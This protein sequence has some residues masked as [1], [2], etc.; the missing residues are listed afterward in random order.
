MNEHALLVSSA[1]GPLSVIVT[2]PASSPRAAAVL[3][4]GGG[5]G[6]SG[7]NRVFVRLARALAELG[8]VVVRADY[9]GQGDS[10]GFGDAGTRRGDAQGDY[11]AIRDLFAWFRER[12][13]DLDLILIGSC[14]GARVGSRFAAQDPRLAA[15]ALMAPA[16]HV[17]TTAKVE[18]MKP[19]LKRAIIA[20]LR[21]APFRALRRKRKP[22]AKRKLSDDAGYG[23]AVDRRVATSIAACVDRVP[24]WAL[25]GEHDVAARLLP[26]LRRQLGKDGDR[27]QIEIVP[28]MVFHG[29]PV[30]ESQQI[31]IERVLDWAR[32]TLP[33]LERR[34]AG[35]QRR[36]GEA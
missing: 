6:R 30:A 29:Y 21:A 24:V 15:V 9:P 25:A 4:H 36:S 35:S 1:S 28:D 14:Y 34:K 19:A 11:A 20:V 17:F 22:A 33:E 13:G 16:L 23:D 10:A 31:A 2:E 8:I 5:S 7:N 3:L 18:P 12:S 32:A 26:K 27:L